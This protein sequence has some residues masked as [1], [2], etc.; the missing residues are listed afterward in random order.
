[1]KKVL[2]AVGLV[3]L[4]VVSVKAED[5]VVTEAVVPAPVEA[6]ITA[7][8]SVVEGQAIDMTYTAAPAA[9]C[10]CSGGSVVEAAP[11]YS[12]AAPVYTEAAPV[13]AAPAADCGCGTPAPAPAPVATCGCE[14]PA[15]VVADC[16]CADPAPVATCGC[17]AAPAPTCCRQPRQRRYVVRSAVSQ[18]RGRRNCCC[19]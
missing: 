10:G 2:L 13:V 11:A 15:P 8:E 12:E 1:M 18:L 4:S 5:A 19:N 9:D 17:E 6:A 3:A 14:A 7:P 16:G